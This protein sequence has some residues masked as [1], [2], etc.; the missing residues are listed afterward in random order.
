MHMDPIMTLED[1]QTAIAVIALSLLLAP[2]WV[3]FITR[4]DGHA[5]NAG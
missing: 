4:R 3:T 5:P 1:Y 2:L